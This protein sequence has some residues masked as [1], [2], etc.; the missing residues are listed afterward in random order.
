MINIVFYG[1]FQLI[2]N[3]EKMII[4]TE[5]QIINKVLMN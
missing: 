2:Y 1:Q 4:L 5:I 3:I